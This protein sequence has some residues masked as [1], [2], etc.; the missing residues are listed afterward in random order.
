MN[1]NE[2]YKK[3]IRLLEKRHPRI[4]SF[5]NELPSDFPFSHNVFQNEHREV[6]VSVKLP[7]RPETILHEDNKAGIMD[8]AIQKLSSPLLKKQDLLLCI[9][10]GLG[11]IPLAAAQTLVEKPRIIILEP[12]PELFRLAISTLDLTDLFKYEKLDVYLGRNFS[13]S[14]VI[15]GYMDDFYVGKC[16]RITHIQNRELYG[17]KFMSFEREIDE[18]IN[19]MLSGWNTIRKHSHDIFENGIQNLTSLFN[20]ITVD[21]LKDKFTGIPAVIVASGP[22]LGKDIQ[23]LRE[24]KDNAIILSCDSAVKPLMQEKVV[25]HMVFSV[26]HMNMDFDKLRF[27]LEELRKSILV[28]WMDANADSVRGYLGTR[29]IASLSEDDFKNTWIRS[30]FGFDFKLPG[31]V[32][33]NADMAVLTAIYMGCEPVL[34]A[35]MD[36][37]FSEGKNH[38]DAAVIKNNLNACNLIKIDGLRGYPVYSIPAMVTGRNLLEKNISRHNKKFIDVSLSG[39][40]I[41]GACIKSLKELKESVLKEKF[42]F[43]K[44]MDRIDWSIPFE[45]EKIAKAMETITRVSGSLSNDAREELVQVCRMSE[46][47]RKTGDHKKSI[48]KIKRSLAAFNRFKSRYK[49]ILEMIRNNRYDD[50][51]DVDRCVIDMDRKE[52]LSVERLNREALGIQK[53][54]Y[55]SVYLAARKI[56]QRVFQM[57]TYFSEINQL[58]N[59]LQAGE[60]K[61]KTYL[62]LARTHAKQ[63]VIWLF[64]QAYH[65]YLAIHP[66]DDLAIAELIS[67]YMDMKMWRQAMDAVIFYRS[68]NDQGNNFHLE[69]IRGN[70]EKQ[71]SGL[72][73]SAETNIRAG[74][75]P[76]RRLGDSR[77]ALIEYLSVYPE[78]KKALALLQELNNLESKQEKDLDRNIGFAYT[79]EQCVTVEDKA[80][81][82][83]AEGEFEKAIGIY[84]GLATVFAEKEYQ[85]R[86]RIGDIRLEQG[87]YTSA[88]WNYSRGCELFTDEKKLAGRIRFARPLADA[89]SL[90]KTEHPFRTTFII[91]LVDSAEDVCECLMKIDKTLHKPCEVLMICRSEE[92]YRWVK[93]IKSL[94]LQGVARIIISGFDPL[95]PQSLNAALKESSGEYIVILDPSFQFDQRCI[96]AVLRKVRKSKSAGVVQPMIVQDNPLDISSKKQEPG[97]CH[98]LKKCGDLFLSFRRDLLLKTGLFDEDCVGIADMLEDFRRRVFYEGYFNLTITDSRTYRIHPVEDRP[99]QNRLSEK[100]KAENLPSNFFRRHEILRISRDAEVLQMKGNIETAIM[101]LVNGIK[102]YPDCDNLYRFI[103]YL[104][105]GECR[106]NEAI[107]AINAIPKECRSIFNR[108]CHV[109]SASNHLW[110]CRELNVYALWGSGDR[111]HAIKDAGQML[112]EDPKNVVILNLK[113]MHS[114]EIQDYGS[115]KEYFSAALRIETDFGLSWYYLGRIKQIQG[116]EV[117]AMKLFRKAFLCAPENKDIANAYHRFVCQNGNQDKAI[118]QFKRTTQWMPDNKHLHYLLIDLLI[119]SDRNEEAMSVIEESIVK[120]GKDDGILDAALAVRNGLSSK[121]PE[122]GNEKNNAAINIDSEVDQFEIFLHNLKSHTNRIDFLDTG[123]TPISSKIAAVF[124]ASIV[125]VDKACEDRPYRWMFQHNDVLDRLQYLVN[126]VPERSD[127]QSI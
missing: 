34:L 40:Y 85:Y 9:G 75:E 108:Q 109:F 45:P 90:S 113:G 93:L 11:Y 111:E 122:K 28:Y 123:N 18:N 33:S 51:L 20:G 95:S 91:P 17:E 36:L 50:Q 69:S 19:L 25:P 21:R 30:E 4:C 58:N 70:L 119:R 41:K 71:L 47:M 112:A 72:L 87:D 67:K 107:Q 117:A 54:F 43:D 96:D 82:F 31:M 61:G 6:N 35:G 94:S 32:S 92:E 88:L 22:S 64:E 66:D 103:A 76:H 29:R 39:A 23:T 89:I 63:G 118:S 62:E 26:D 77:R 42:D 7:G 79:T 105:I 101:T 5:L 57:K 106:F 74:G 98:P 15:Y 84:E 27:N 44:M 52:N 124:G 12:F 48:Q 102:T 114:F 2:I 1:D 37:A 53:K 65:A 46:S 16:R 127:V 60:D 38:V 86:M 3:N 24:I 68:K 81:K 73:E 55:R 13:V 115:A 100:W 99:A 97:Y 49:I 116:S 8:S 56:H 120:F 80:K 121:R 125:P 59:R 126:E 14:K 83:V 78:N 104:L 110:N 10:M